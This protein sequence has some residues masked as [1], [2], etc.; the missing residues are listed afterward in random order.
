[1]FAKVKAG[2]LH[3]CE[4]QA[5]GNADAAIWYP[6]EHGLCTLGSKQIILIKNEIKC[7]MICLAVWN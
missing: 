7:D 1:M 3:A 5:P 4:T 2:V 6:I